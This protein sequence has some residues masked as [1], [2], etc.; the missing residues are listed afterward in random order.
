MRIIKNFYDKNA[1]YGKIIAKIIWT[2]LSSH[3]KSCQV[4][5]AGKYLICPKKK[6][7]FY[8]TDM[9]TFDG[10]KMKNV[11]GVM[12]DQFGISFKMP[13]SPQKNDRL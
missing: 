5:K 9:K 3:N 8:F 12:S 7:I 1:F 6:S 4:G 2:L 13:L 10:V 11:P